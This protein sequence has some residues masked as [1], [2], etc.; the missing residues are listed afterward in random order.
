MIGNPGKP[1]SYG[2]PIRGNLPSIADLT[3]VMTKYGV[4]SVG[5]K[6]GSD[7]AKASGC[8]TFV[9]SHNVLVETWRL[10]VTGERHSSKVQT[11]ELSLGDKE[12]AVEYGIEMIAVSDDN[13]EKYRVSPAPR[14]IPIE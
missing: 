10:S 2:E 4:L 11:G 7:S 1:W 14:A 12:L 3:G 9:H 5:G 6:S 8:T 13:I